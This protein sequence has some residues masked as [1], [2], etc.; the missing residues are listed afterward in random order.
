MPATPYAK[1]LI[2]V[3][4]AP[5]TSGGITVANGDTIQLS[6]ESTAQWPTNPA[7]KWEIYSYTDRPNFPVPAGWTDVDGVYTYLGIGPPPS[8]TVPAL[9]WW[10]KA[11]L[12]LT[13]GGGL[14]NGAA[15]AQM[16]DSAS[17]LNVVSPNGLIS[18]VFGES[19][20]FDADEQF[21]GPYHDNL[22]V[23]D[24]NLATGA[25]ISAN[26]PQPVSVMAGSA[27]VGTQVSADDHVHLVPTGTPIDVGTF[28]DPGIST[29]LAKADHQ[30]NVPFSAVQA[31]LAAATSAVDLNGQG[32]NT[33]GSIFFD[34]A[35]TPVIEQVQ[36]TTGA[37][38][39]L[40]MRAQQGFGAGDVGGDIVIA[41][42]AGG[43]GA[44]QY[45]NIQIELGNVGATSAKVQFTRAGTPNVE[46][47]CT[48]T[49]QRL[50]FDGGTSFQIGTIGGSPVYSLQNDIQIA[51]ALGNW[52]LFG[53]DYTTAA[54]TAPTFSFRGSNATG[55]G[56]TG[57]DTIIGGATGTAKDGNVGLGGAPSAG[58][59]GK[60]V[61]IANATTAPTG[62]PSS[63]VTLHISDNE[64]VRTPSKTITTTVPKLTT[65]STSA[66]MLTPD[67]VA[68]YVQTVDATP[69]NIITYAVPDNT[70]LYAKARVVARR[71]STGD[72]AGFTAEQAFKR[73]SAGVVTPIG[74]EVQQIWEDLVGFD[75][76]VLAD[77]G[78]NIVVQVT[79]V[80][81]TVEW[82]ATL[83]VLLFTP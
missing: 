58:G 11:L 8:F 56:S 9:P 35:I 55:A 71:P 79:G 39:P 57:A 68:G 21:A 23:L 76:H 59:G 18:L 16:V 32:L 50:D 34:D 53:E 48:T 70:V 38:V 44:D 52:K 47:Y 22:K 7:P 43:T 6:A 36:N 24:S 65:G 3:N 14:L 33:V 54:S 42:G 66:K 67:R 80:A 77:G 41:G 51:A 5:T 73:H 30:H 19:N 17:G 31:A 62:F 1:I 28:N 13:I 61:H 63:G 12:R 82:L 72:S 25:T 20:Q 60:I 75:A 45:G 15:S 29:D 40:T 2:S 81:A 27:G 46:V 78:N 26:V 10:G 64:V 49:A 4:A 37:G 83:E 74:T 69:T